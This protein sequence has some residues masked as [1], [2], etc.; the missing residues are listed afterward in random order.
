M[1]TDPPPPH[2]DDPVFSDK[3]PPSPPIDA[4]L[5]KDTSPLA[6][7]D[8]LE[9]TCTEPLLCAAAPAPPPD[10]HVTVLPLTCTQPPA[11]PPA[12]PSRDTLP[13]TSHAEVLSPAAT[14]TSPPP[15]PAV[16][17]TAPLVLAAELPL[18]IDTLPVEPVAALP[19][20]TDTTPLSHVCKRT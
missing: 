19:D 20:D 9:L 17:A 12:P 2:D 5:A 8:E 11:L 6:V 13:P 4:P 16:T 3:L 15:L 10:T 18:A 14:L 7:H 1:H